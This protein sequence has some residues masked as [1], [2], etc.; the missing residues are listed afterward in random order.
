M[1]NEERQC[2]R[3]AREPD[4]P[5]P[6]DMLIAHYGAALVFIL[7]GAL[8]ALA[9][10]TGLSS[11][12]RWLPLHLALIGGVS[13]LVIASA[14]FF[15]GAFFA[16]DLPKRW[17]IRTQLLLW[18][19][20]AVLT[21]VGVHRGSRGLTDTGVTVL[22]AGLFTAAGGLLKMQR[23]S[24]QS[25]PVMIR[26][27]YTC[28][29]FFVLGALTGAS[30]ANHSASGLDDP[31]STHLTLMLGGWLGCAIVGTL[32]TLFPSITATRLRWPRLE[33]PTYWSWVG[34]VTVLA[35]GYALGSTVAITAG[36]Y[37]LL[38][39]AGLLLANIA[40][41]ARSGRL[42]NVPAL[43][44]TAAQ[45]CLLGGLL[46][47]VVAVSADP[48]ASFSAAQRAA[49]GTLLLFGWVAMTVSGALTRLLSVVG[50]VRNLELAPPRIGLHPLV[51]A[52]TT[53]A[54]LLL[55]TAQL[56]GLDQLWSV[57]AIALVVSY[58][59]TAER[60]LALAIHALR[61]ARI[62]L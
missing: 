61:V 53:A 45:L 29:A 34:G 2:R 11:G 32:H 52:L 14:L 38:A 41:T 51:V 18:N 36:W 46:V 50:R 7:A 23:T 49:V 30:M 13:Q 8:L 62:S 12:S 22:L 40:A 43:F 20:G 6:S 28:M 31:L 48:T 44:V 15:A 60:V 37:L 33:V 25:R 5:R 19:I 1:S 26:W 47:A 24:L 27:Y 16:T 21:V 54:V 57:A 58:A 56:A 3:V 35:V 59:A 4:S 17:V 55:A 9:H 39:A 10:A 42:R